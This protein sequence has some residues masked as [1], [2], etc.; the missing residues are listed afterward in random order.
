MHLVIAQHALFSYGSSMIA[1]VDLAHTGIPDS[2]I[3]KYRASAV[4]LIVLAF[5]PHFEFANFFK[6]LLRVA[7]FILV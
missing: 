4:L 7:T 1:Y 2:A 5:V 3:D 6:R